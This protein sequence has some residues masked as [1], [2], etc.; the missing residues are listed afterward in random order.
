MGWGL[1]GAGGGEHGELF[2]VHRVLVL[3]DEMPSGDGLHNRMNVLHHVTILHTDKWLPRQS[4][5]Y[6]YFTIKKN[7]KT[8]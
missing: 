2:H 7:T 3:Q 5:C 8:P 6:V 4:L 1:P